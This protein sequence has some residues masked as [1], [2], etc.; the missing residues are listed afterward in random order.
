[1]LLARSLF[2]LG[3]GAVP[4][5]SMAD[6]SANF[7]MV[8]DY[9]YR[10]IFQVDSSASAG[11]D[12]EHD[13]GFYIGTWGAEVDAGIETDLYFGFGGAAGDIGWGVGY[14]GYYYTDDWDDT[15]EEVNLGLSY[16]GLALDVALGEYGNFGTPQDYTFVS[17]SYGFES[18]VYITFGSFGDEFDGDYAEFGYGFDFM[19]LD[20]SMALIASSDLNVSED[21]GDV[22]LVFGVS[23]GIAIGE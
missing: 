18:G 5:V 3:I 11:L 2:L 20:L 14:T 10:G 7:G 1:M 17:L 12:Y 6:L 13:S 9:V 19:G 15:Y 21:P 4:A 23:K 8:S 16:G 22:N